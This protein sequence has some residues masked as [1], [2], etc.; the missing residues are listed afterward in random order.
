MPKGQ[1]L[2]VE[3]RRRLIL[4]TVEKAGRVKVEE[5]SR[6]FGVS[7]VTVRDD[8]EVLSAKGALVRSY[9]GA[10]PALNPLQDYAATVKEK[11]HHA[12]KVRIA[13]AALKFVMPNQT[14]LLD[15]GSTA[16]E[17]AKQ[18]RHSAPQGLTVITH[19]LDIAT[20]LANV[21]QISVIMIGGL[22]RHISHSFVGPQAERALGDLHADHFFLSVDGFDLEKGLSTPDILEAQLNARMMEVSRVTTVIADASKFGRRSVSAIGPLGSIHRLITDKRLS[23][24]RVSEIRKRGIEVVLV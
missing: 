15:S 3:E 7:C 21:T 14:V 8:L 5:L 16:T 19:S 4:D 20:C 18:L 23:A 11:V 1:K 10:I 24:D 17:L 6:R 22:L 12:E 13:Q 9:G 2:L